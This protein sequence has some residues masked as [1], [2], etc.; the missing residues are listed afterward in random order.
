[1]RM[2]NLGCGYRH[3]PDWTNLDVRSDA[4]EVL[5]HDLATGVPFK[6][7]SFDVVYHSHLLEHLDARDAE[8]LL[9]EC[10]RVLA[11]GGILRLAVPDLE[12]AARSYL[13]CLA[14][15]EGGDRTAADR[16][17][18]AIVELVDQLSR[19]VSGGRM[20]DWWRQP[21]APARE[22]I[23]ERLGSEAR[24]A[25]DRLGGT[26][27]GPAPAV[28]RTALEVGRFRLSG[29]AH[30]WMY[31]R[32]SLARLLTRLGFAGVAVRSAR[33]S[34]IPGFG[35]YG[36]D[37]EADGAVRKP[38]SLFMEARK[39]GRLPGAVAGRSRLKVVHLCAHAYGGAGHAAC[40]L[41]AG[42]R[43]LGVDSRLYV[44][45][46]RHPA[47]GI[48]PAPYKGALPQDS[49]AGYWNSPHWDAAARRFEQIYARYPGRPA[50]LELFSDPFA[51]GVLAGL[52]HLLDAD[53]VNFHWLPGLVDFGKD[54]DVLAG[55]RIVWTMHDMNPMTGGCHYAFDC[56]RWQEGCGACPQLG[57][58]DP[59]D[60]S[61]AFFAIKRRAYARL[62]L[63]LVSPS[64]WLAGLAGQSRLLG[65]RPCHVIPNAVPTD[66]FY[67][68][69]RQAARAVLGI[70][71]EARVA[72]FGAHSNDVPRKG[73]HLLRQVLA[74]LR[75]DPIPGLLLAIYGDGGD[76]ADLGLPCLHLGSLGS[77]DR[78][79]EAI[80]AADV[81]V[82]PSV[83][84]NLPNTVVESLACGTPVAAFAVG[85]LPDMVEH[86]RTGFLAPPGDVDALARGIRSLLA[87][88]AAAM[89]P[90][91]RQ[92]ALS[93]WAMPVQAGRYLA[94]YAALLAAR[95]N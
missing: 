15:A 82:A 8:D 95:A 68:L 84:D 3:H 45:S 88:E 5:A 1:M 51:G 69:D 81:Y 25:M 11:P 9:R 65:T 79:A 74:R 29:E 62:D 54:L 50:G 26:T 37:V 67:P 17:E 70:P 83:A 59:V 32:L 63:T 20:L 77:E 18:W 49:L 43:G 24:Q 4:P 47:V 91:C 87:G 40:R 58:S 2:L 57:S 55:R 46:N 64:R 71:R 42:L 75:D 89:R 52:P 56:S 22:Y 61:A 73:F 39:P 28:P 36:L 35:R 86:G 90:A 85:G 16:H 72:L 60:D 13:D 23:I 31:D 78:V 44:L 33:A 48:H 38:D 27:P 92:A 93:N 53:I 10:L 94:L 6:D 7:D 41:H 30:L 12:A 80:S 21:E 76:T 34:D 66:V 14:Q 19:H